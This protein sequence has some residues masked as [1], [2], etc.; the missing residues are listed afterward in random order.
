ME[1][2]NI[3]VVAEYSETHARACCPRG[4]GK[5]LSAY[6]GGPALN[7]ILVF[8]AWQAGPTPLRLSLIKAK[9]SEESSWLCVIYQVYY[10]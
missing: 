1:S 10:W 5:G 8:K 9:E 7:F 2:K 3:C 6:G 4:N